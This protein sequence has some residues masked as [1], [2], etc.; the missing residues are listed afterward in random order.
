MFFQRHDSKPILDCWTPDTVNDSAKS[1]E[2]KARENS[3][4][5]NKNYRERSKCHLKTKVFWKKKKTN[6]QAS[7]ARD[8]VKFIEILSTS[9][10]PV[11]S[12]PQKFSPG[13][14]KCSR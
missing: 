7:R 2:P 1:R 14:G 8:T 13:K 6:Q 12:H 3:T 5:K 10:V 11:K 9:G 4:S